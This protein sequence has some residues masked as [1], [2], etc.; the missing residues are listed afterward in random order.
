MIMRILGV[1]GLVFIMALGVLGGEKKVVVG[2]T[3]DFLDYVFYDM[4][5]G[6]NVYPV[7]RLEQRIAEMKAGGIDRIYLRV[8]VCG[9]TLYPTKAG[10]LYGELGGFHREKELAKG[11]ADLIR[12][13]HAYDPL[14]ETI[15]LGHKYGL[16]VWAW[17]SLWDDA[18]RPIDPKGQPELA[19]YGAYP[20]MDPFFRQHPEGYSMRTGLTPAE[21]RAARQQ[22][23]ARIEITADRKDRPQPRTTEKNLTIYT[24]NDN[25]HY[26]LY[27]G[28][29][30]VASAR[31]AD[32]RWQLTISDLKIT[33][34]FIKLTH[35]PQFPA[36]EEKYTIV[37]G[38]KYWRN[39]RVSNPAGKTIPVD[40]GCVVA[41][42]KAGKDTP[43][44]FGFPWSLSWDYA[45]YQVGFVLGEDNSPAAKYFLGVCEF[46]VPAVKQHKLAKF[47]ELT[48]Y[49]FDGFIFNLRSHSTN[50]DP[51]QYGYNPEL[52]DL[53]RTRYGK[54]FRENPSTRAKLNDLRSDAID[55]FL[56]GCKALAGGRPLYFS[57]VAN[58]DNPSDNH[59][60][61]YA[62]QLGFQ[63]HYAKWF[64]KGIVDGIIMI[65]NDFAPELKAAAAGKPIKIGKFREMAF[66]PKGSVFADDFKKM[67]ANP[68]LDEV[69]L[70][71][72]LVLTKD[73]RQFEIIRRYK[74]Q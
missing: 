33:S 63:W 15:R 18:A 30:R 61:A 21:I 44:E 69:E 54:E 7:S 56:A 20:F 49:D 73:P 57:G 48:A 36:D 12:T 16:Q 5:A 45:D 70:Y 19:Q 65:G 9:L 43:L 51:G 8:N 52:L 64:R 14:R 68:D 26:T 72:T 66:P 67:T 28:P 71:E 25:E 3:L 2:S 42:G 53:Y 24:S 38:G 31:A 6:E 74:E 23:V 11:A 22:S 62:K 40:W 4:P 58:D 55:D 34:L 13:V 37:L 32:G 39:C 35:Q 60:S 1:L 10:T 46:A 50:S 59:M 47:Q 17:E 29:R 41:P 27:T